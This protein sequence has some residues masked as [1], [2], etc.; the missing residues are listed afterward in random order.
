MANRSR[1]GI[2]QAKIAFWKKATHLRSNVSMKTRI[3]IL[4]SY[5]FSVW[6]WNLDVFKSN[7]LQNQ[8]F[9]NVVLQ[10]IGEKETTMINNLKNRMLLYVGH[11]K[12]N[13]TGH[14][15]TLLRRIGGRRRG[16]RGRGRPVRTWVDDLRDWTGTKRYDDQRR[17]WDICNPQQWTQQRMNE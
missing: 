2:N 17:T 15:D 4:M 11:I 8:R 7:R 13:T 9:R 16:K 6:M 10:K 5:L 1:K 14:Y 12:R 3:R